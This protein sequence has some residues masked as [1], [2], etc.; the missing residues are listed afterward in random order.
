M[1]V[2]CR[3][4]LVASFARRH[5]ARTSRARERLPQARPRLTLGAGSSVRRLVQARGHVSFAGTDYWVGTTHRRKQVE[6]R[7][8]GDT[9]EIWQ[10][11]VLLRTQPA[12]HD[13][14][15]ERGAFSTPNGRA[16]RK[17][18][19]ATLRVEQRCWS[20][21]GTEVVNLDNLRAR[22]CVLALGPKS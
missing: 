12:R 9:V 17:K 11:D 15:K 21:S 18:K 8:E 19:T 7:L 16:H 14:S 2:S 3:G 4:V 22:V 13:P 5:P 6:V 20:Q 1:Q 10:A